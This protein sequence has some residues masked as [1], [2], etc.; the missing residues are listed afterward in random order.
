VVRESFNMRVNIDRVTWA[1][2]L[3][4]AALVCAVGCSEDD[5]PGPGPSYQ[6]DASAVLPGLDSAVPDSSAP[7]DG[8]SAGD[9][10][11]TL[12]DASAV[13]SGVID[14]GTGGMDGS[15]GPGGPDGSIEA[16]SADGGAEAGAADGGS[17]AARPDAS[18]TPT[19]YSKRGPYTIKRVLNQGLGTI[20]A[21]DVALLPTTDNNDPSGFTVYLPENGQAGERFPLLTFGNG[22]FCSPTF[23]DEL[24]NHVVSHGFVV[25]AANTS[26]VGTGE[27]MLK[28]VDWAL[29]QNGQASSP[30]SG[31]I[32]A[33]HIGAFGHSQGGAGTCN[34][35]LDA[36]IDAIV[37]LSGI[38]LNQDPATGTVSK[39]KGPIFFVTT[40]DEA[41]GSTQIEDSYNAATAPAAY[42]VTTTGNHDEYTD[43]VD[44]PGVPGLTSNDARNS[45][46]GVTAWFDWH[47][48]GKTSARSLF[49]GASCGFCSGSTWKTVKSKG[50]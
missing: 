8:S 15:V 26:T 21:G 38:P 6:Q 17:D 45:R 27:P 12:F 34:A 1:R 13:D 16:G 10:A 28:A 20:T 43:V 24:I 40:A 46:A 14:A 47:L 7:F 3:C 44:D 5:E 30:L 48:K 42:G 2:R 9:G 22:T 31:R 18:T 29:A 25:V 49:V 32:D 50:F 4:A 19:D 33:E 23:Y 41:A 36:R 35:G 11:I 39:I 37:P